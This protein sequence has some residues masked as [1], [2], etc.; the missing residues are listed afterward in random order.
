[1]RLA[2]LDVGA[3][4][5]NMLVTD[6]GSAVPLPARAWKARTGLSELLEP[7]GSIGA[8]GRRRLIGAVRQ[9]SDELSR[10][11]A[12]TVFPYA[13]AVV[14]DSPNRDVVLAEVAAATG[15][16]LG[17]LAGVEEAQLTFL[18]A[19]R[20][21]GWGAGPMLVADIGGGSLEVAIGPD[22]LPDL[23][24]SLPMGARRLTREFLAGDPP[25]PRAVK[26]LRRHVREQIHQVAAGASWAA[27]RTA[28]ATSRTFQQLAR[29]TGAAPLRRGPFVTRRLERRALRPWIERLAA[30]PVRHRARLPGVSAHRARQILAGAIVAHELMRR[31]NL[32][33]LRICPWALREGILLRRLEADQPGL[34][35][36]GWVPWTPVMP[37]PPEVSG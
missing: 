8:A 31:L 36:A 29:L 23:A 32:D 16:R 20:W 28:V 25:S 7:D 4:T 13:T 21:L 27:P 12:D 34:G 26:R 30:M 18:A 22:R 1:M 2:V 11:G 37:E 15:V 33:S 35:N 24:V 14:R 9:A 5:V 10:A 17:L 6:S 19:R 3:N